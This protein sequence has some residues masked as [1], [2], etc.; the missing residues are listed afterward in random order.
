MNGATHAK[1]LDRANWIWIVFPLHVTA[2][3]ANYVFDVQGTILVASVSLSLWIWFP[4]RTFEEAGKV[5]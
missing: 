4:L 3:L 1:A 2:K 5:H